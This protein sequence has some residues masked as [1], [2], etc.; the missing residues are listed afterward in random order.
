MESW[1]DLGDLIMPR[2]GIKPATIESPTPCVTK[3]LTSEL[4]RLCCSSSTAVRRHT[5]V[6]T[7]DV[8]VTTRPALHPSLP[9][10]LSSWPAVGGRSTERR[11][12]RNA[13]AKST[14][15]TTLLKRVPPPCCCASCWSAA[16]RRWWWLGHLPL[17]IITKPV[18]ATDLGL[19]SDE[20]SARLEILRTTVIRRCHSTTTTDD[21]CFKQRC[22]CFQRQSPVF[23][24]LV[25]AKLTF[26]WFTL[27]L[28]LL[29]YVYSYKA[30]CG[31]PG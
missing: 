15:R 2:S 30:S 12:R 4:Q 11:R 17:I 3:T 9:S 14:R 13:R 26:A 18:S 27:W 29:P 24:G 31:R 19:E 6:V 22:H 28:P 21:G 23:V 16:P 8:D 25:L 20:D 10:R 5:V 7:V 1:V